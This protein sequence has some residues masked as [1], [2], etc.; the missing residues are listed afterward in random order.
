I[1]LGYSIR[2]SIRLTRPN[3]GQ[4]KLPE[5]LAEHAA[6]LD[7]IC[8]GDAAKAQAAALVHMTNSVNR[9]VKT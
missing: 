1:F 8:A 5:V 2:E 7:A 4:W 3:D 9:C 6:I